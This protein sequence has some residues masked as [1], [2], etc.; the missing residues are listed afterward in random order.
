MKDA[1]KEVNQLRSTLEPG[2]KIDRAIQLQALYAQIP[3]MLPSSDVII[4]ALEKIVKAFEDLV[5]VDLIK[6]RWEEIQRLQLI[7]SVTF[8]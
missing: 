5:Q 1:A 3:E 2:K 8:A 7:P 6:Q 4:S